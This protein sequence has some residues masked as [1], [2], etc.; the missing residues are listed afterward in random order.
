MASAPRPARHRYP[1]PKRALETPA[2]ASQRLVSA[3]PTPAAG[4]TSVKRP[5]ATSSPTLVTEAG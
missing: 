3:I 5:P 4:Q 1:P 2:S